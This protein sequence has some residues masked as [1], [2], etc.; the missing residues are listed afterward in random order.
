MMEFQEILYKI[1]LV[2]AAFLSGSIPFGLIFVRLFAAQDI[3]QHG[4]GNIGATNVRRILGTPAGLATLA[5]DM[6]K[7]AV[8]VWLAVD[9]VGL[10][11]APGRWYAGLVVFAAVFGHL[12]PVY[13]GLRPSGKGVATAAGCFLVISPAALFVSLLVYVLAACL[14]SR[15]SVASLSATAMLPLALWKATGFPEPVAVAIVTGGFIFFRH[16]DNLMRLV[17]GTEPKL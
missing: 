12:Y 1:G 4:S 15:G 6:L 16:R 14:F 13:L 5:L 11:S 8:P 10:S 2:G 17:R 7:G 3:R 9:A